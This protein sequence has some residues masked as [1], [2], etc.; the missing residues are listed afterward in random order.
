M[1]ATNDMNE[2]HESVSTT[3]TTI[4]MTTSSTVETIVSSSS[5]PSY[6]QKLKQLSADN[7]LLITNNELNHNLNNNQTINSINEM[8]G[9]LINANNV[10]IVNN[11][12]QNSSN[13]STSSSSSLLSSN[14]SNP[15]L[16]RNAAKVIAKS[17]LNEINGKL[18]FFAYD[19]LLI[20]NNLNNLIAFQNDCLVILS[21]VIIG[22]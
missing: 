13:S 21:I 17:T 12:S 22:F 1:A 4:V 3:T 20:F 6:A 15:W 5:S 9:T 19:S 8:N 18:F 2:T 7:N 10:N 14:G 16:S 11:C